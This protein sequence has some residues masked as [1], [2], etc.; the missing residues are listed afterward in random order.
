MIP[1]MDDGIMCLQHV[2]RLF[3]FVREVVEG[4]NVIFNEVPRDS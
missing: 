1:D 2:S 3:V 4:V